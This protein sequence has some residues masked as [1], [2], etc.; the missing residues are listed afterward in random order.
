MKI[1]KITCSMMFSLILL[2][3]CD[4]SD[5]EIKQKAQSYTKSQ[6]GFSVKLNEVEIPGNYKDLL[7]P[8]VRIAHVQQVNEPYLQFQLALDGRISPKVDSDNY[9]IK[10]EANDLKENFNTYYAGKENNDIFTFEQMYTGNIVFDKK[11]EAE[12][13]KK[14]VKKYVTA[15]F[16]S[17]IF[18]DVNNPVHMEKL[19]ELARSIQEFNKINGNNKS[20]VE[21]ITIQLPNADKELLQSIA[22]DYILTADDAKKA[23]ERKEHYMEALLLTK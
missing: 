11:E 2:T 5:K 4:I 14:N 22:V 8:D 1:T 7:G 12:K 13:E 23:L 15:V 17:N 18:L 10:K 3:S 19:A 9:K 6:Y 20:S 16:R 21:D